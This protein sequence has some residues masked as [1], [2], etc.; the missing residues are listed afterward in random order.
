MTI[1]IPVSADFDQGKLEAQLQQMA[2]KINALGRQI[3]QANKVQFN[4]ISK[5][6]LDDLRKVTQQFEALKRVSGDFNRRINATGQKGAGFLDLDWSRMYPDAGSRHRQMARA[7]QY[8]TGHSFG[9]P[10][11]PSAPPSHGGGHGGGHGGH[12]GGWKGAAEQIAHSAMHASNKAT[13]GISGVVG[14]SVGTGM[15]AGFGA[16]LMGLL[17]GIAAIG[18]GK[19]IEAVTEKMGEAE[20]A[21]VA[22]DTLKRTLGDVGI[23]F[24]ALEKVIHGAAK[25][26]S[27]TYDEAGKL[28][29]QFAKLGNV[30]AIKY[31]SLTG[32]IQSSVGFS[33]AFGLDPS[34]GTSFFGS[35]RGLRATKDETGTKRMAL[36]IGET[37]AKS[38]AFAKSDEVMSAISGYVENQT[39]ASMGVPNVAG[40]AGMFSSMV[41]SGIPGLDPTGAASM[42][43]RMNATLSAGGGRGEASQF[44]SGIV[45]RRMGLDPL[46]A[47]VLREGG[48]FAT[49]DSM[50]G[51]G[52]AY[53]RY[54]GKTG[55]GGG[56]TY[57]Q[58]TIDEINRRYGGNDDT[59]KLMRAQAFANHAGVNMNQAMA[60]M[61]LKPNQMGEMEKYGGDLSKLNA[62]GIANMSKALFGSDADRQAVARSLLGRSD[63]KAD[64]KKAIEEAMG[65][66]ADKQKEVLARIT[67]Q[68]DQERTLG[69]DIRDSKNTLDN[70]ATS[71]AEKLIPLTQEMR[72]GIMSIAGSGSKSPRQIMEAVI[73][74]ESADRV[75]SIEGD[76][77]KRLDPLKQR[78]G[79]VNYRLYGQL[80]VPAEEQAALKQ[81]QKQLDE[82]I[83]KLKEEQKKLLGEENARREREI[84]NLKEADR[85]R[86]ESERLEKE[87][88]S[89]INS[90]ESANSSY[91]V[92]N[93]SN[94]RAIGTGAGAAAANDASVIP[95]S[96][97]GVEGD[98]RTNLA[99]FLDVIGASEGANYNTLVGHGSN[100]TLIQDLSQHPNIVGMRTGDGVSTAAGKYQITNRTWRSLSHGG[101][102][103]FTP[104][105]QDAAAIE[106]LKRRGAYDDVLAGNWEEAVSKLGN[107]WQSL[108]SGTSRHQGKRSWA[109]FRQ[110]LESAQKRHKGTPLPEG[111]VA[112]RGNKG[113]RFTFDDINIFLRDGKGEVVEQKSLATRYQGA[114]PFGTEAYG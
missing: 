57:L 110:Q 21:A 74:A 106:L 46:Q 49:N 52:S 99:S 100:N 32:E 31:A 53:A 67:A 25:N 114:A 29:Q 94:G 3:A 92:M 112:G 59:S 16:G 40:Y 68:Y 37:I 14:S 65:Q 89:L 41:G 38:D 79:Q 11:P 66:S 36:L 19:G 88:K 105:N 107:E 62:G 47:Q 12:A 111:P 43:A 18:V 86:W 2:Q 90:T 54:M 78:L 82:Q 60:I 45:G 69:K 10:S 113:G 102:A 20:D 35:M 91:G 77:K 6:S 44:F 64:D 28:G 26:V 96:L 27:I 72:H 15:S 8:V 98:G 34:Q 93:T 22:M 108:P 95:A 56:G 70:I 7:F 80:G 23:S 97:S 33:R 84:E 58:A 63:V 51:A 81:E 83:N 9:S 85:Q 42:L 71:L 76:Y 30:P 48:L 17:G 13:G 61:S 24:R 55:P 5:T 75:S 87:R 50:F 104:E 1:K 109:F 101:N 39:R 4:P 103:P 73:Q